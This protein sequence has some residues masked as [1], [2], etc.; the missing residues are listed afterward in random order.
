MILPIELIDYDFILIIIGSLFSLIITPL[1]QLFH[2][3][4]MNKKNKPKE[5]E[6]IIKKLADN[7]YQKQLKLVLPISIFIY[8]IAFLKYTQNIE[9]ITLSLISIGTFI[10]S[11]ALLSCVP[12]YYNGKDY[13]H[14]IITII[15]AFFYIFILKFMV[16]R[17]GLL[18]APLSRLL[19][20]ILAFILGFLVNKFIK[21]KFNIINFKNQIFI[22]ILKISTLL[23]L[24]N[25]I[26]LKFIYLFIIKI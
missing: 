5:G 8:S 22:P 18:G 13:I 14:T 21:N 1:T 9:P 25:F 7:L 20:F 17:L 3:S 23:F 16:L 6:L 12:F 15:S 11:F 24:I 26:G 4:Y 2:P 19:Y 10:Q